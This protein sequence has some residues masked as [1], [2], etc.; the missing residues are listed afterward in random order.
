[1]SAAS[2]TSFNITDE[3]RCLSHSFHKICLMPLIG[4][5][6]AR[7][8]SP[9]GDPGCIILVGLFDESIAIDSRLCAIVESFLEGQKLMSCLLA[10][11]H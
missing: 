10:V 9:S 4:Y 8:R 3:V 2:L 6:H 1:M 11:A 5:P 7:H